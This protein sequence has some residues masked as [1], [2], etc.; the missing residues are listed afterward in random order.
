MINNP[1]EELIT[2]TD[3]LRYG[4]SKATQASLYYGHGTDN[5]W[6]DIR[7]LVL[8]SLHLPF[9]LDI[10]LWSARLT[11]TEKEL[12]MKQFER[13]IAERIP[14]PYLVNTAFFCGLPFYVDERV[15]IPRSPI[16]ELIEARFE[17][18]IDSSTVN[19]IL[20]VC[21]GS[22]CIAI[23]CCQ[24]F[25][26]ALVDAIELSKDALA[27]AEI[28]RDQYH[29]GDQ[30]RL[31]ASD[32]LDVLTSQDMYDVIVSNPPYV[33]EEEMQTLP[34]EYLHEPQLALEAP[35]NGLAVVLKILKQA[36]HHLNEQGIL[37]MEVGNSQAALIE[38]FPYVAF[39]WIEFERGGD[40]VFVLTK[41]Q[42]SVFQ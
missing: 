10:S 18:W 36:Y 3:F 32:A 9:D 35:E 13:R 23:A 34:R 11:Q 39:T 6:D 4:L 42:L 28:N 25:D 8:G 24:M 17:P 30:L 27:V 38:L 20:D 2:I 33:G 31:L 26:E 21:T 15:L 40:G 12:L 41:E 14:V 5:A 1:L 37:V 29:M 19:R 16:A 7:S 22:G